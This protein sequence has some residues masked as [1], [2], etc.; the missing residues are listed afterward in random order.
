MRLWLLLLYLLPLIIKGQPCANIPGMSP[1]TA[2]PI[3]GTTSFV[4]NNVSS[5]TA[6]TLPSSVCTGNVTSNNSFWYKFHCYQA[7]DLAFL[8]SPMSATDDYDWAVFDITGYFPS[9]VY[10]FE[11]VRIAMNLSGQPGTTGCTA[12]GTG[13]TH[14]EGG[15]AGTQYN[16]FTPIDTGHDYLLMVTN[17]SNSGLG[18]LLNF[19]GSTAV[20]TNS[21]PPAVNT[22]E[23]SC[24]SNKLKVIFSKDIRC[25]SVTASGSEFTV[26]PGNIPATSITS[27]CAAG[28]NSIT[29]LIANLQNPLAPGNYTLVVNNGTDGDTFKD[30][31]GDAVPA[32]SQI[33]FTVSAQAS[34]QVSNINFTGCAPSF[35]DV[36]VS[37]PV[38][39]SSIT[40]GGSEFSI[41]PGNPVITSVQS[42]DCDNGNPYTTKLRIKLQNPLPHGSYTLRLQNGTDGNTFIDTCFTPMTAN[43]TR[44]VIAQTIPPVIDSVGFNECH[45]D[46]VVLN[47]DKPVY[48]NSVS[49]TGSEFIVNPGNIPVTAVQSV[50]LPGDYTSQLVLKL[51]SPLP[52]GGF[53]VTVNNG[54]DANSVSDTCFSFIPTGYTKSFV[55]TQ[56]PAPVFD[57]VQATVCAPGFVKIYYSKPI[58]CNSISADGSDFFITGPS[59]VNIT[60]ATTNAT[61]SQGYTNW[62]LLQ[63][64]QPANSTGSYILHN[65]YGNDGNGIIDTCSAAQLLTE[66]ISFNAIGKPSPLFSKQVKWGCVNDTI[67]LSHPGGNGI[68]SWTWYFSDGSSATGQN[69]SH[70][71]PVSTATAT[72]KLIVIN[73]QCTDSLSVDIPLGNSFNADFTISPT[74]TTCS[75]KPISFTNI[76]TGNNL[77]YDWQFGD[78]GTFTGANPPPYSYAAGNTYNIKLIA[79][80]NLGCRDT[81][82]HSIVIAS[83]PSIDFGALAPKYCTGAPVS[84][85]AIIQ[86]YINTYSWDN[87]DGKTFTDQPQVSFIY[88]TEKIYSIKL[89]ATD[90]FC[91][92]ADKIKTVQV[93]QV[94]YTKI[95]NDTTFC[96][97]FS[98]LIGPPKNTVYTYLWNTG[99][100]SSQIVTGPLT[101]NYILTIGNNGCKAYDEVFVKVLSNC[102]IKI[103]NA[104]TPNNDGLND[105]LRAANA[106]LAKNFSLSIYNRLGQKVFFT[107]NPIEGW[108]GTFKGGKLDAGTY[109]WQVSYIDPLSGKPVY[110]KGTS[111]LIR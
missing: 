106:D 33:P 25:A 95:G 22:V 14:C 63:F 53:S 52:G 90:R 96:P 84:L 91:G 50:C 42:I 80:D 44:F 36:E 65:K 102:L 107:N 71:F 41:I 13:N 62:I 57:S 77:S 48:C 103:P 32:G 34:G 9:A 20:I 69:V 45:P 72:V 87:G 97:G 79:A 75:G 8:I 104:F 15:A 51:A 55:T 108:D 7:G 10:A 81:A 54:T 59:A 1:S 46:Q 27:Q 26:M 92:Q 49:A 35:L 60:A 24:A 31:C 110:E 11:S 2:I 88:S 61:C 89:S 19:N 16:Y 64:A 94:P 18:Y 70:L 30:A 3:C 23:T 17:W 73:S 6:A 29:Q 43:D 58:L 40:P 67:A 12:F 83:L 93:Y 38:L 47:F 76:S 86:G 28:F 4:Q 56:A 82:T 105:Y 101:Y 66:T 21:I 37:N 78:N 111:I 5:C 109:V 85:K 98:T 74:D 99:A 39:C 100:T 68:N